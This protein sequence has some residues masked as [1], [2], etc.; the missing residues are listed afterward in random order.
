MALGTLNDTLGEYQP[1]DRAGL[2]LHHGPAIQDRV[3]LEGVDLLSRLLRRG[4]VFTGVFDI[5]A[6]VA[7]ATFAGSISSIGLTYIVLAFL[8]LVTSDAYQTPITLR[9]LDEAPRLLKLLSVPLVLLAPFAIRWG[10][11]R[12]LFIQ[13]L[14][15]IAA[16]VAARIIS[17]AILRWARRSRHLVDEAVILGAGDV[18]TELAGIFLDHGEYGITPIGFLDSVPAR[19]PLPLLGDVD[20]LQ[21]VLKQRNV[22]RVIVAFG[23]TREAELVTVLRT[24]MRHRVDVHIVPR[25]FDVGISP[26][27]SNIDDIRGIPLYRVRRAALRTRAWWLK[28]VLD[29]AVGGVLCLIS[30][31]VMAAIAIAVRL[32]SPGPILFR[33]DRVG[34]DGHSIEVLK[35]RTM[36]VND[37]S[38]TKW[39]V[40]VESRFTPIGQFLRK[41]SLDELP[42]FFSILKG[43]MS[44]V[45]PR[46]ERP[47]FVEQFS[48]DVDGYSDRHR[49][50]VGLTGWAQVHGLRGDTSIEERARF[51]NQYIEHWSFW[52]DIVIL[53]RTVGEVVRNA[54]SDQR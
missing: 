8:T 42:Q 10:V 34:Q 41:T 50:P 40:E 9:A 24:A 27:G 12:R 54:R 5:L 14:L 33:Q 1:L 30:A 17:Y 25:F 26:E 39:S 38:D 45:G 11:D 22:K 3:S 6:L 49:V 21:E 31:P 32:T 52:R 13:A 43:D 23:P 51:D 36:H 2:R 29:V 28:R 35:F 16:L 37:D 18:G 19:L 44:L 4:S 47:F 7:A 53:V 20:D 15:T 48:D 46:P